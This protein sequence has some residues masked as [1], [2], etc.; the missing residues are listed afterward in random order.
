MVSLLIESQRHI[1]KLCF[2]DNL[3]IVAAV[4]AHKCVGKFKLVLIYQLHVGITVFLSV[5]VEI[6]AGSCRR[7]SHLTA[8]GAEAVT[9]VVD[10]GKAV[11]V[12]F[13]RSPALC[14]L[15]LAVSFL[16]DEAERH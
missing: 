4:T 13:D 10:K 6:S 8:Y 7:H 9:A 12:V 2:T 5:M 15:L 11:S 14:R 3:R 16:F 1:Q